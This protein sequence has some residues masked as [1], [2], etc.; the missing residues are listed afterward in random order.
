M[1]QIV[2]QLQ[3]KGP[4]W[5]QQGRSRQQVFLFYTSAL[6]LVLVELKAHDLFLWQFTHTGCTSIA[7]SEPIRFAGRG[8][9][10]TPGEK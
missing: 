1:Q 2:F 10:T 6:Q 9:H 7:V 3:D 5:R 4:N 8:V